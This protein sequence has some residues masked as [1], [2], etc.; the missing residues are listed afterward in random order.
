MNTISNLLEKIQNAKTLDF[1]TIF[2]EAIELFKKT[3][4]HGFLLQLFTILIMLPLIIIFYVPFIGLIVAQQESGYSDNQAIGNFFA[5]MSLLYILV[6][7]VGV[8]VLGAVSV[9]LNAGFYRIIKKFDYNEQVTTS[10]FFHFVKVKYLTK[11]LVLMLIS[12]LIAIPSALLCYIPLL[13]VIVPISFFAIVMAFNPDLSVGEVVKVSFKLGT[14]KWGI[15]LGLLIVASILS[16]IIGML[17]CGIGILF[18]GAF[19]YHTTYL[20]YK[21]VIG[22]KDNDDINQIGLIEE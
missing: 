8:F 4:L 12:M 9:A 16:Q 14:K 1:G 11:F 18:T 20:V 15:T 13:Y 3:W 19:P 5:G 6:V 22:F 2:G 7:I 21:N 10:D 17:L